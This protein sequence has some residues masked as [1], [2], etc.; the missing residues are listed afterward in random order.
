MCL[1]A[2]DHPVNPEV[3][4]LIMREVTVNPI[5]FGEKFVSS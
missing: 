2:R 5:G 4:E 3:A 1:A